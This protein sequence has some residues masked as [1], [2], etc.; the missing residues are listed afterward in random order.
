MKLLSNIYVKKIFVSLCKLYLMH[1]YNLNNYFFNSLRLHAQ[2]IK[3]LKFF[4]SKS[5]VTRFSKNLKLYHEGILKTI[6]L[7]TLAYLF[8]NTLLNLF[9]LLKGLR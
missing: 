2:Y 1:I 9:N 7:Q 6:K 4:L 5:S 8:I 3:L